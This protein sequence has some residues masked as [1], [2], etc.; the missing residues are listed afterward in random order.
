MLHVR[1][2]VN[3]KAPG[4]P[5]T[6]PKAESVRSIAI[7]SFMLDALREHLEERVG[8][9]S[10]CACAGSSAAQDHTDLADDIRP[11]LA[12]ARAAAGRPALLLEYAQ[13][14]GA[15]GPM[16]AALDVASAR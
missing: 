1:R 5:L 4:A 3:S 15:I 9:R 11:S 8:G 16:R 7:P 12:P 14:L 10:R 6:P 2:Q 13:T